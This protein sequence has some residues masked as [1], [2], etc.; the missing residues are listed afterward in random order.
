MTGETIECD[1]Q[2]YVAKQTFFRPNRL[3]NFNAEMHKEMRTAMR[4][5]F[6]V[7]DHLNSAET[8]ARQFATYSKRRLIMIKL[9]M[10]ASYESSV[11]VHLDLERDFRRISRCGKDYCEDVSVFGDKRNHEFK[12]ALIWWH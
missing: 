11:D 12:R 10:V 8:L 3:N 2:Y 6:S 1:I 7:D 4:A 5:L 9:A